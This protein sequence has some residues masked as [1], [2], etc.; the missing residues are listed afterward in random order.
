MRCPLWIPPLALS[1]AALALAE[2]AKE[3]PAHPQTTAEGADAAV[4]AHFNGG[5]I[6]ASDLNHR[7]ARMPASMRAQYAN[8]EGKRE[9]YNEILQ[10]MLLSREAL[11]RGYGKRPQVQQALK[12]HTVQALIHTEIDQ[13]VTAADVD[14]QAVQAYYNE[15]EREYNRPEFRRISHV[16]VESEVQALAL[17]DELRD[18]DLKAFRQAAQHSSLDTRT[19]LRGGDLRFFDAQGRAPVA[20]NSEPPPAEPLVRAAFAIPHLGALF[21]KPVVHREHFSV[22]ML[23][24]KR[25]AERRTLAEA[26][27]EIRNRL[28]HQRRQEALAIFID[29][30]K[31]RHRPKVQAERIA[32]ITV[33]SSTTPKG[34]GIPEGFPTNPPSE[35]P[36]RQTRPPR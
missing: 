14:P 12:E 27:E 2:P 15:H 30:L 11:R 1:C 36:A 35:P 32:W 3:P 25:P 9:L 10:F 18:K 6:T 33:D 13:K 22:V 26:E 24:G 29:E 28:L 20:D 7:I 16:E 5:Q 19:R 23:T 8:E 34:N 17:L 31:A 21:P 4:V